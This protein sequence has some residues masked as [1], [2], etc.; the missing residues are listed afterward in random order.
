MFENAVLD[1]DT[2][3]NLWRFLAKGNFLERHSV[4]VKQCNGKYSLQCYNVFNK[5]NIMLMRNYGG[6]SFL[7]NI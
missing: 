6:L 2:Q 5:S 3:N 7:Y 4:I 1:A